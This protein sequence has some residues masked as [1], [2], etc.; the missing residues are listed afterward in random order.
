MILNCLFTFKEET[1]NV[2]FGGLLCKGQN[3]LTDGLYQDDWVENKSF[4]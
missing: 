2:D 3:L 4:Y 1:L